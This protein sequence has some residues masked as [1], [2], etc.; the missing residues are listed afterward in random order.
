MKDLEILEAKRQD[1]QIVLDNQKNKKERNKLG[2]FSTPINLAKELLKYGLSALSENSISFLDPAIGT[3]VFYSALEQQADRPIVAA[4]GFDIDPFYAVP[5]KN[6]WKR[7][8]LNIEISDFTLTEPKRLY[9]LVICNPPYVR[10]HYIESSLK[11]KLQQITQ[12]RPLSGYAGL[13]CYF[14]LLTHKWMADGAIAGWLIPSE[15]MDVNYGEAIKKYLLQDVTLLHIHRFDP[16]DGQFADALVSSAIVWIKKSQPSQNH[17]VKF[18]FG[19]SL[20]NPEITKYI[21]TVDL[22]VEKKWTRF[23]A[24]NIR[25]ASNTI[26]VGNLFTIKRGL[27]TG[28][29]SFFIQSL[30]QINEKKLPIELFK[31][32]LPSARYISENLIYSDQKGYPV[33]EKQL[34]LLD[35]L[36]PESEIKVKHP[37]LWN[38]LEEGKVAKFNEAYICSHRSP[39]YSQERRPAAPIVCTYMGRSLNSD[40]PFRFLLNRSNATVTNSYLMMYP[41]EFLTSELEHRHDLLLD[42]WEELNKLSSESLINEGRVY[43]GGLYKLEPKELARVPLPKLSYLME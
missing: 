24:S 32:I 3:G 30:D 14:I 1:L 18:T 25:K 20:S 42:I 16:A 17:K 35:T 28:A 34:F 19:G 39:W 43:G 27:A 37:S 38:Y 5:S 9:N 12:F 13:Y 11:K 29:N 7:L 21:S 22:A 36:M 2:Q 41:T 33:L 8:K 40:K 23:P 26:T 4:D 10:H 31:P 6:L 15:F